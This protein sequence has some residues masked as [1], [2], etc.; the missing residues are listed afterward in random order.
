MGYVKGCSWQTSAHISVFMVGVGAG[1]ASSPTDT[2]LL[3]RILHRETQAVLPEPAQPVPEDRSLPQASELPWLAEVV[4]AHDILSLASA[5]QQGLTG[6][7]PE[8]AQQAARP[9]YLLQ[10]QKK[11][12]F[13]PSVPQA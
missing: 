4:A 8:P 1:T 12:L 11:P 13:C 5:G 6:P 10:P 2:Q 9:R 7:H 3:R